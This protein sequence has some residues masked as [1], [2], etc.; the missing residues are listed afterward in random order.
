MAINEVW[1]RKKAFSTP[2]TFVMNYSV[3]YKI[4]I[5]WLEQKILLATYL[6]TQQL[7]QMESGDNQPLQTHIARTE[8]CPF[9][10]HPLIKGGGSE[11]NACL[12]CFLPIFFIISFH[13]AHRPHVRARDCEPPLFYNSLPFLSVAP[14]S[15]DGWRAEV[16][17]ERAK[18]RVQGFDF[19]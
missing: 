10:P 11:D 13:F 16:A 3:L 5:H 1:Y 12:Y 2:R 15:E 9:P 7:T 14:F 8:G 18:R 17:H 6:G 19:C 4:S